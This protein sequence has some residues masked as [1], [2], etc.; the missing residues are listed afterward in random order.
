MPKP[1]DP[2]LAAAV[3]ASLENWKEE[4]PPPAPQAPPVKEVAPSRVVPEPHSPSPEPPSYTAAPAPDKRSKNAVY[5]A[6]QRMMRE[7]MQNHKFDD[8]NDIPQ[9]EIDVDGFAMKP[10]SFSKTKRASFSEAQ[11]QVCFV[12][13]WN[14]SAGNVFLACQY[15]GCTRAQYLKWKI[16]NPLFSQRLSEAQQEIMDRAQLRLA[17]RI[18]L[19]RM[20][21]GVEIH[22]TSLYAYIKRF[23]PGMGLDDTLTPSP[24]PQVGLNNDGT[25]APQPS[26]TG[27]NIPRPTR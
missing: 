3:I 6:Q 13:M 4:T 26:T 10:P 14:H 23:C 8:L 1:E 15:A 19:V 2:E 22:D 11:R 21:R 9:L 17:Q 25:P 16:E 7:M 12:L 24:L 27:S 20:P 5:Q 18:G